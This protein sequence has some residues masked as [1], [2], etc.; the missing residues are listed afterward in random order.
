MPAAR[1]SD[2]DVRG[3]APWRWPTY[4]TNNAVNNNHVLVDEDTLEIRSSISLA[5]AMALWNKR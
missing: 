5:M 4:L 3:S 2:N 1:S